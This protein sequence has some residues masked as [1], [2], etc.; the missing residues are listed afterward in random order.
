[1]I[2]LPPTCYELALMDFFESF[3]DT[4]MKECN[5]LLTNLPLN[6]IDEIVQ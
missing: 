2:S 1:M 6:H 5:F 4:D 3:N